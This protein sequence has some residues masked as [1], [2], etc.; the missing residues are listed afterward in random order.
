MTSTRWAWLV[1]CVICIL[2]FS[3]ESHCLV[4][5]WEGG[6]MGYTFWRSDS[7]EVVKAIWLK[8]SPRG[9]PSVESKGRLFSS[10]P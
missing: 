10:H 6:N 3:M 9:T 2:H 8:L 1:V 4:F 7:N 5:K